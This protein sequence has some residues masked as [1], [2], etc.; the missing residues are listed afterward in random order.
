METFLFYLFRYIGGFVWFVVSLRKGYYMRQFSLFAWTHVALLIIVTQSYL[1]IQ[2]K[3][4]SFFVNI[5]T[6]YCFSSLRWPIMII[7]I[8]FEISEPIW[9]IDLV[10]FANYDDNNQRRNG[11]HVWIFP[12]KDS[13]DKTKSKENMGRIPWRRSKNIR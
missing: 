3:I 9:G 4:F 1:I 6:I 7:L 12:W 11:L 8:C 2:V 10:Y 5:F 13:T